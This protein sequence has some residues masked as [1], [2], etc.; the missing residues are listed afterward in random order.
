MYNKILNT[1]KILLCQFTFL[2][3]ERN[4]S[5]KLDLLAKYAPNGSNLFQ[6]MN[7]IVFD[8]LKTQLFNS[9]NAWQYIEQFVG[10]RFFRSFRCC[11]TVELLNST[12][13]FNLI[14][15]NLMKIDQTRCVH[16]I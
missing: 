8:E 1:I 12:E 9:N 16:R 3:R 15:K 7:A 10:L 14:F 5:S 11:G 6:L 13:I 4:Y 2:A